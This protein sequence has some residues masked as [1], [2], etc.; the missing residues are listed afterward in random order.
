MP[1]KKKAVTTPLH[2][3]QQLSSSLIE[4]LDKACQQALADAEATLAKLEKQRGKADEKLYK[5]RAK[6]DEATSAGKGKALGK[7]KAAVAELETLAVTLQTRQGETLSYIAELKRDA[8]QSLKLAEGIR[9]VGEAAG[10]AIEANRTPAKSAPAAKA[11][12]SRAAASAKTP[13]SA[14]SKARKSTTA[15]KPSAA[16]AAPKPAATAARRTGNGKAAPGNGAVKPAAAAR[17]PA[18]SRSPAKPATRKPAA[19]KP[20]AAP[21]PAEG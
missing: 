19:K 10:K 13:A 9:Q 17:T 7:S 20:A 4:H 18:T 2:L 12:A 11:P 6:L 14:A 8:E 21:Q 16:K 3:L 1:A 15:A 5:A